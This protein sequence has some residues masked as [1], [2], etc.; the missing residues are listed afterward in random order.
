[1]TGKRWLKTAKTAA[2]WLLS[3]SVVLLLVTG[4][5]ITNY[6]IVEGLTLGL[7]AKN[8]SHQIH[9]SPA[10]WISFLVILGLHVSLTLILRPR[11][12]KGSP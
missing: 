7:L 8:L 4:L 6:S 10:L 1:M 9:T 3:I 12:G 5:G 2:H 11:K